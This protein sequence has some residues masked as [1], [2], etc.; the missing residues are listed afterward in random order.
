MNLGLEFIDEILSV[1]EIGVEVI[2]LCDEFLGLLKRVLLLLEAEI[3]RGIFGF[4]L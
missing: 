3:E 1:L 4:L 2:F